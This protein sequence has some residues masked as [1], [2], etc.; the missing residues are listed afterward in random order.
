MLTIAGTCA[1]EENECVM[2]ENEAVVESV[3]VVDEILAT[4]DADIE[5]TSFYADKDNNLYL[6]ECG[7]RF[8]R[9]RDFATNN[10]VYTISIYLS[11]ENGV[12]V[13]GANSV[14][15]DACTGRYYPAKA[16][17]DGKGIKYVSAKS[18]QWIPNSSIKQIEKA[19]NITL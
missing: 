19:N 15:F 7:K 8:I 18:S 4:I 12:W 10:L 16:I 14:L 17:R 2:N 11:K 5:T 3:D 1:A 6:V 9:V 13:E